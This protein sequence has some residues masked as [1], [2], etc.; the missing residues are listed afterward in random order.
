MSAQPLNGDISIFRTVRSYRNDRR[1]E[2]VE[3]LIKRLRPLIMS[4][5]S[6]EILSGVLTRDTTKEDFSTYARNGFPIVIGTFPDVTFASAQESMSNVDFAFQIGT[7]KFITNTA[8][9]LT[10]DLQKDLR[11][12]DTGYVQQTN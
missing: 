10:G 8:G 11:A 7:D 2:S 5:P 1:H 3:A 9:G 6:Y 12:L 4:I